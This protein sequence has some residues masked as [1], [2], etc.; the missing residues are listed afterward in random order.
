MYRFLVNAHTPHRVFGMLGK[1][2][3][4]LQKYATGCDDLRAVTGNP[5]EAVYLSPERPFLV[6]VPLEKC[7][8]LHGS[9]FPCTIDSAHPFIRTLVVHGESGVSSY[10]NSPLEDFYLDW[11]PRCG[12]DTVGLPPGEAHP[13]LAARSPFAGALPWD[14]RTPEEHEAFWRAICEMDY[15]DN[16]FA[17][18]ATDG[19][20]VWGPMSPQAGEAELQRL[21]RIHASMRRSGYQRHAALDGDIEGQILRHGDD[22]RV[23]IARGQHR[24]AALAATGAPTAPLRLFPM[25]ISRSDVESWPNVTR[26]FYSRAQALS[27]FDRMF[28][29]RQPCSPNDEAPQGA[30]F[31]AARTRQFDPAESCE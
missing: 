11:Q 16:G 8:G 21:L 30:G 26:G 13:E 4:R 1:L 5:L 14:H 15:R 7:L 3:V 17:L 20:K 29:G 31:A 12:A 24:I 23:L 10:E 6:D 22:Y 27:V 28:A 19:W 25:T 9:A 2:S 18:E